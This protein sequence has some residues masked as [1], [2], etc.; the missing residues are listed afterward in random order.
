MVKWLHLQCESSHLRFKLHEQ[1][2]KATFFGLFKVEALIV[3]YDIGI[4]IVDVCVVG[5]YCIHTLVSVSIPGRCGVSGKVYI[6]LIL[7]HL[8]MCPTSSQGSYK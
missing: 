1:Q 3:G 2:C 5:R 8:E 7:Q 6:T 4:M